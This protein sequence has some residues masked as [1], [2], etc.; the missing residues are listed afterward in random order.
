VTAPPSRNP[1]PDPAAPGPVATDAIAAIAAGDERALQTLLDQLW[2][3]LVKY[4]RRFVGVGDA[5]KD[6][7][8]VAFVRFWENRCRWQAGSSPRQILY[9]LTRNAAL[10]HRASEVARR[11]RDNDARSPLPAPAPDPFEEA[12][13]GEIDTAVQVA[14]AAL[15]ERQRE[16]VLLARIHGLSRREIAAIMG[17]AE[18]TV[19]NH[20]TAGV[21]RLAQLLRTFSYLE[22]AG[23]VARDGRRR[24]VHF[25]AHVAHR[26]L[27]GG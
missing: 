23:D 24:G 3:P 7:V 5:A 20:L 9:V 18:Q 25:D 14:I 26:D 27:G 16:A 8:Q 11:R 15:P 17:I 12:A 6:A 4:A 22:D 10:N 19:A 2:I 1:L 13:Q 21:S